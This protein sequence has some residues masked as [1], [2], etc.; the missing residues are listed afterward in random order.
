MNK[1]SDEHLYLLLDEPIYVLEEHFEGHKGEVKQEIEEENNS[2]KMPQFIGE[3][4]KG[5][6]ILIH[7]SD[8]DAFSSDDEIFLF[9][10]LNALDIFIDDV[11]IFKVIDN[12]ELPA[13]IDHSKCIS[14]IINP[15]KKGLY[16]PENK[17][18]LALL[19][20]HSLNKIR[21]DQALKL[22]F[23]QGLQALFLA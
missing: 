5:I 12:H 21:S 2:G 7:K 10:G 8:R 16:E 6:L 3:N 14:F 18:G 23:W 13:G 17:E 19:K 22:K 4:K 20:C 1:L 9:K 11:A 15:D